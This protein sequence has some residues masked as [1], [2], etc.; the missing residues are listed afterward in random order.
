[1]VKTIVIQNCLKHTAS[2]PSVVPLPVILEEG[3]LKVKKYEYDGQG[4]LYP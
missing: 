3:R 1:M 4:E 2:V